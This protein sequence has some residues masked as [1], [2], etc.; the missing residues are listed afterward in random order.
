MC[1]SDLEVEKARA[2]TVVSG[3]TSANE[4]EM[5]PEVG[6]AASPSS[7]GS[8]YNSYSTEIV[9]FDARSATMTPNGDLVRARTDEIEL[10]DLAQ[11]ELL[12][13]EYDLSQDGASQRPVDSVAVNM[14]LHWRL[15]ERFNWPKSHDGF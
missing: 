15:V 13:P 6:Q 12:A 14:L 3:E 8:P 10:E 1:S 4:N 11:F 9:K 5:E 2:S 7:A